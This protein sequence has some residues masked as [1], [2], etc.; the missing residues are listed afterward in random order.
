MSFFSPQFFFLV[1]TVVLSPVTFNY[2]HITCPSS[3]SELLLHIWCGF[4]T[5]KTHLLEM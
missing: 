1:S 3:V 5:Q 2:C 4:G